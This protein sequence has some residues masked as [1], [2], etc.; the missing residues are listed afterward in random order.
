MYYVLTSDQLSG[1]HQGHSPQGILRVIRE[2]VRFTNF[3]DCF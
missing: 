2:E 1:A 3:Q